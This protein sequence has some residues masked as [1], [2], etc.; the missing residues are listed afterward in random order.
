MNSASSSLSYIKTQGARPGFVFLAIIIAAM[1]VV[2][3]KEISFRD[4]QPKGFRSLPQVPTK[5]QGN[6]LFKD[7]D[8][9]VDT[10]VITANSF[11]AKS[12][13][14]K[15]RYTLSDTLIMKTYKGYYFFSKRSGTVWYL[16]LV[17]QQKNGD[18]AYLAMNDEHFN[19]FLVKL[20]REIKI[21]SADLGDG[22]VY[23]IDPT[24]K[25]LIGLIEK[26]YFIEQAK[27]SKIK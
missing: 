16:R 26:G 15:D 5:M 21:D 25:Q 11:Y 12:E 1:A 7:K 20:S 14:N 13:P 8:G 6:Y 2:A 18:L 27:W 23:Q 10:V 24:P 9:L 19:E 3:C 4:P 22:M 17:K